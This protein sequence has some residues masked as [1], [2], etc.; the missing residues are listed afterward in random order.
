MH[1][2]FRSIKR[3]TYVLVCTVICLVFSTCS[4]TSA[5]S[6]K[7]DT[8]EKLAASYVA[9]IANKD[10]EA[11]WNMMP[12]AIQTHALEKYVNTKEEALNYIKYSVTVSQENLLLW[13]FRKMQIIIHLA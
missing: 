12:E 1:M 8:P 3:L 2:K 6:T 11:I 4:N 7:N 5:V 10:Y 9:A 13:D